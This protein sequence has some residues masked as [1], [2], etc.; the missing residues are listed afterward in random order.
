MWNH[1]T[2]CIN[3][4]NATYAK[5]GRQGED[6]EAQ[7]TATLTNYF[8]KGSAHK[9]QVLASETDDRTG[10]GEETREERG[11]TQSKVAQQQYIAKNCSEAIA[12]H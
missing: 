10:K 3:T 11:C 4:Q 7:E 6:A 2:E 8:L 9:Q 1:K 5:V 12:H